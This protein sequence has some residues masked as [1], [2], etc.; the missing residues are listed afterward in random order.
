MDTPA[1]CASRLPLARLAE[2]KD[3]QRVAF[4]AEVQ[5]ARQPVLREQQIHRAVDGRAANRSALTAEILIE[6]LGAKGLRVAHDPLQ[7]GP[8]R[9]RDPMPLRAQVGQHMLNPRH[10]DTPRYLNAHAVP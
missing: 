10:S 1:R 2:T 8:A 7:D 4:D 5:P 3:F 6:L 9:F